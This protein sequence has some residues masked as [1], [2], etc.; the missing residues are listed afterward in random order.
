VTVDRR[1]TGGKIIFYVDGYPNGTAGSKM[2]N[3]NNINQAFLISGS[4]S[5][6]EY[7]FND[8]IDE[9]YVYNR[10]LNYM[11]IQAMMLPGRTSF[12]PGFWNTSGVQYYNNC[13]NYANNKQT[14][15]FAQPGKAA[16]AQ[17]TTMSCAAVTAG[18]IADRL[19]PLSSY[20]ASSSEYRNTVALV[21]APGYDYHW[22]RL[23]SNG[24]WTHK[25]GGTAATNLD[26]SGYLI[27]D[28]RT[29]NRGAYTNFCGF[30]TAWSDA[31]EG[32]GREN[33]N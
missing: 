30:F 19:V 27:T 7:H 22:Y 10:V 24:Y 23:D 25:P 31:N 14:N 29:A 17:A 20:P 18:A 11:D 9:V 6:P 26:N 3:I 28:P 33:V 32:Q 4:H 8:M 13:Y 2:G 16:G 5:Q 1:Q 21:V 12:N 15:T